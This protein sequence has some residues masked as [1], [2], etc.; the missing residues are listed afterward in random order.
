MLRPHISD[1]PPPPLPTPPIPLN[2]PQP[3]PGWSFVSDTP[4]YQTVT[5]GSAFLPALNDVACYNTVVTGTA[6]FNCMAV[7]Q[8]GYVV[9][10]SYPVASVSNS[11]ASIAQSVVSWNFVNITQVALSSGYLDLYGIS[12]RVSNTPVWPATLLP[13]A[14]VEPRRNF[15]LSWAASPRLH[16]SRDL[17]LPAAP[18]PL[19]AGTTTWWGTCTGHRPSS[20]R[21]TAASRGCRRRPTASSHPPQG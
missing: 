14:P 15:L 21:T 10:A 20:G 2:P 13:H 6:F 17:S 18:H 11:I 7:G 4:L 16:C 5:A 3:L 12:W 19:R 8:F 9:K 1:D